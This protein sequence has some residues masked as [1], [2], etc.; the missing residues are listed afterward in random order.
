MLQ[1]WIPHSLIHRV[2]YNF[3]HKSLI[4]TLCWYIKWCLN[5]TSRERTEN[6]FLKAMNT[7]HWCLTCLTVFSRPWSYCQST[8]DDAYNSYNTILGNPIN[9]VCFVDLGLWTSLLAPVEWFWALVNSCKC[10]GVFKW[11]IQAT[12]HVAWFKQCRTKILFKFDLGFLQNNCVP[13]VWWIPLKSCQD[14][15]RAVQKSCQRPHF[16]L[17]LDQNRQLQQAQ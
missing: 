7:D 11:I 17:N 6:Q 2:I 1:H 12:V 4:S 15:R 9:A 8:D 14:L 3:E 10:E 5:E 13:Y 16:L